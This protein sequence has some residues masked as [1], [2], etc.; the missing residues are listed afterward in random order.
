MSTLAPTPITA[1]PA[2]TW[3]ADALH[4]SVA[5]S[6]RHMVSTFRGELS[7]FTGALT[8]GDAGAVLEASGQAASIRTQDAN[9]N[10]HLLAPDFFDVERTPEV[11]FRSTSVVQDGD[12]VVVEG[13]LTMKGVARPVVFRGT[14]AGPV[15]DPFGG[16][17]AGLAIETVVDR[18]DFGLDWNTPLPGGGV[19]LGHDVT[20]SAEVELVLE[21]GQ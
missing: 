8:V 1:I 14:L 6:V 18:R 7:E 5:F 9:L 19:V 15:D 2:G 4:S 11:S 20:I 21:A 17:R 3:T 13:D 10:A 16:R 12:G